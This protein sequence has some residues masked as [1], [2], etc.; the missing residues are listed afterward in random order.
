MLN[1]VVP[2]IAVIGGK[3]SGKTTAV[4]IIVQALKKKE[5]TSMTVKHVSQSDFSVDRKDTD[6]WRHWK[7]G[8]EIVTTVSD[9][10]KAIMIRNGRDF[11]FDDLEF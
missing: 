10:E 2:S 1:L 6:T 9:I 7:A 8:A 3:S 11:S 4:E 5:L